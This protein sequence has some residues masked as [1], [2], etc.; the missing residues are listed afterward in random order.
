MPRQTDE[1][2]VLPDINVSGQF[3]A[4]RKQAGKIK[5]TVIIPHFKR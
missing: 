2:V 4:P 1:P 3:D 5:F